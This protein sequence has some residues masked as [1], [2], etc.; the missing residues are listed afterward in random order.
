MTLKNIQQATSIDQRRLEVVRLYTVEKK[1]QQEIAALLNVSVGTVNSDIKA[2]RGSWRASSQE[3]VDEYIQT[4]MDK[5]DELYGYL[6]PKIIEGSA[7]H[8]EVA[9][10]I[11]TRQAKLMGL[12]AP[13]KRE[14]AGEGGGPV[15]IIVKYQEKK[16]V[17]AQEEWVQ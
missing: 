2:M 17:A 9:V 11:L 16:P 14:V 13:E 1:T 5:L 4:Q 12:D 6:M 10:Q 7:R 3:Q 15:E 8:V